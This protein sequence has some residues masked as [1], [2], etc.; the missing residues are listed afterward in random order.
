MENSRGSVAVET[1]KGMTIREDYAR[2]TDLLIGAAYPIFRLSHSVSRP[3]HPAY[4]PLHPAYRPI[5][6]SFSPR[7]FSFS[8]RPFSFSTSPLGFLPLP[9]ASSSRLIRFQCRTNANF[10]LRRPEN[11]PGWGIFLPRHPYLGPV[12]SKKRVLPN[13]SARFSASCFLIF[14][15][16]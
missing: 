2:A 12:I 1:E 3:L 4:R 9:S 10:S 6:F 5:P 13:F 7:P 15:S 14:K 8:P 11:Y 16:L